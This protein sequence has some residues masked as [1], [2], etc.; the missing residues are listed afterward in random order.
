VAE[1]VT[2]YLAAP[3]VAVVGLKRLL[4]SAFDPPVAA[5]APTAAR[6]FA[7]CLASPELAEANGQWRQRRESRDPR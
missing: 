7:D 5:V 4:A 3:R 1:A 6:L 2:P